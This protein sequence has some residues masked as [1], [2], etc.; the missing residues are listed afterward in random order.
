MYSFKINLKSSNVI[1]ANLFFFK[2]VFASIG[3]SHFPRS[4]RISLPV[5]MLDSTSVLIESAWILQVNLGR[6]DTFAILTLPIHEHGGLLSG[7][8]QT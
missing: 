3:P 2:D 5:S 8:A 1:L 7:L 4:F 6:S